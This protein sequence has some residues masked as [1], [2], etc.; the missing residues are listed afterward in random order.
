MMARISMLIAALALTAA[1]GGPP[2]CACVAS[3]ACTTNYTESCGVGLVCCPP[4][5]DGGT[6]A[7]DGG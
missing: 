2:N 6:A 7:T 5:A 4:V 1:C 3:A